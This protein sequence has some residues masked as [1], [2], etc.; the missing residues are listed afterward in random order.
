MAAA[1]VTC[2]SVPACLV[3]QRQDR[4]GSWQ[5][6]RVYSTFGGHSHTAENDFDPSQWCEVASLC[7]FLEMS[8]QLAVCVTEVRDV[9]FFVPAAQFSVIS[10][11]M[12]SLSVARYCSTVIASATAHRIF[13]E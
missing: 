12:I 6:F 5:W 2:E 10:K 9:L 13:S 8:I 1:C 4:L 7:A 11:Q 3:H